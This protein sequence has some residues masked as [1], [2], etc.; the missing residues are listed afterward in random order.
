MQF[1]SLFSEG[2]TDSR[3]A[4]ILAGLRDSAAPYVALSLTARREQMLDSNRQHHMLINLYQRQLV[5]EI[6]ELTLSHL[7]ST[8]SVIED[9]YAK[10]DVREEGDR[11]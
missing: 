3:L 1:H 7:Q 6:I 11:H 4:S 8:L 5:E 10:G 2:D 9:A